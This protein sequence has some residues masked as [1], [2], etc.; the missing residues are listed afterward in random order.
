M[1]HYAENDQQRG[2]VDREALR[3]R[4]TPE[5]LVWREGL[6]EWVQAR[7]LP[8]LAD[9]FRVPSPVQATPVPQSSGP[10]QPMSYA[11]PTADDPTGKATTS[12]VL[13][14]LGLVVLPIPLSILAVIFGHMA[15]ARGAV[16]PHPAAGQALA[17][18][19]M[20]YIPLALIA[21]GVTFCGGVMVIGALAH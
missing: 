14:I 10:L 17:G 6:G 18:L 19:I 8:E 16:S 20:G 21:C 2:P 4:I 11:T 1:Y 13:G 9:L 7:L 15:R 12:M 5:T 3:G